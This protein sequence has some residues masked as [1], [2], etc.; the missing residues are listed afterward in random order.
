MLRLT[1]NDAYHLTSIT[2]SDIVLINSWIMSL[3]MINAPTLPDLILSSTIPK[4]W[5]FYPKMTV[6]STIY[7]ASV[8][9][10]ILDRML[11]LNTS[12][13]LNIDLLLDLKL[14]WS[15]FMVNPK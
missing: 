5:T 15:Q 13:T 9:A 8:K 10:L 1:H 14:F 2:L 4:F 12:N 11:S 6:L 7:I 3:N